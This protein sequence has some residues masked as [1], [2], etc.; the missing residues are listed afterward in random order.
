LSVDACTA[1]TTPRLSGISAPPGV[2]RADSGSVVDFAQRYGY[3][4]VRLE[5]QVEELDSPSRNALWTGP[6]LYFCQ[7]LKERSGYQRSVASEHHVFVAR[8]FLHQF[9]YPYDKIPF[10]DAYAVTEQIR[11]RYFSGTWFES[12][13][14]LEVLGTEWEDQK[15]ADL[16][17]EFTNSV[18][19]KYMVGYRFVGK[20]LLR[21]TSPEQVAAVE[22]AQAESADIPSAQSH[23]SKSISLLNSRE[24]ANYANSVKESISALEAVARHVT[25]KPGATLA[26]ALKAAP[27][28]HPAL[29]DGWLKLYGFTSDAKGIRHAAKDGDVEVSQDL[30]LYMLVTCS[31]MVSYLMAQ[32]SGAS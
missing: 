23:L 32:A 11:S 14:L 29:K 4:P 21:L 1:R 10:D 13:N 28:L 31:A 5:V 18:L 16:F 6:H 12:L 27:D 30:A 9:N 8:L 22:A 26:D 15:Q 17:R 2:R 25:G 3:A 19:E 20:Q 7:K 24:P